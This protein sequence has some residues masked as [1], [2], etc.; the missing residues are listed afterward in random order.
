MVGARWS[1]NA[2][3]GC[4]GEKVDYSGEG[5]P[6]RK[7]PARSDDRSE[8]RIAA[9]WC[10]FRSNVWRG[11][12]AREASSFAAQS[13]ASRV[14]IDRGWNSLSI[15]SEHLYDIDGESAVTV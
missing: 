3:R 12:A 9:S 5:L 7:D 15:Q 14:L 8:V 6:K 10:L 1:R 2:S 13:S 11:D 4:P